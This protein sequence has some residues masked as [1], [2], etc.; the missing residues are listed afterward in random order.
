MGAPSG[1]D[2]ADQAAGNGAAFSYFD[3][4]GEYTPESSSGAVGTTLPRL[5]DGVVALNHDD[6]RRCV[7]YDSEGRFHVDL[8][9]SVP[10]SAINTY[11]WHRTNR[12]PQYFSLW[13]SNEETPPPAGFTHGKHRGWTLLAVVYTK[14]L[15]EGGIH[16][17]SVRAGAGCE[18]LGPFRHL[19]WIAENVGQGTF[20]TEID[21][22]V[23][24]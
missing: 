13:A 19:L 3:I 23:A 10:I 18:S 11:S 4:D 12:A 14:E 21:V 2:Y 22:H 17:S 24:E 5:N 8:Q 20:F 9:R 16:G 6:T 15:G 1:A 7:W